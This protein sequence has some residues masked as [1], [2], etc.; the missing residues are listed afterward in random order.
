ME[1]EKISV[2]KR[3]LTRSEKEKVKNNPDL[4]DEIMN[5]VSQDL[6]SSKRFLMEA[7]KVKK[8]ADIVKIFDEGWISATSAL[9][10]I[11][12]KREAFELLI[13]TSKGKRIV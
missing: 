3:R 8:E 9:N 2:M 4:E 6:K 13:K 7:A 12:G 10:K 5:D 1:K 11:K